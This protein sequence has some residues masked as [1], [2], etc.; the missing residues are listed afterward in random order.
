M[1]HKYELYDIYETEVYD[2]GELLCSSDDYEEI[3]LAAKERIKV[4]VSDTG[5]AISPAKAAALTRFM[6]SFFADEKHRAGFEKYL[7]EKRGKEDKL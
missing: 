2:C 6:V 1:T 7:T 4:T 3:R 5:G